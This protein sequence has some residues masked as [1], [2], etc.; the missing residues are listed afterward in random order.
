MINLE[1]H[2]MDMMF[3]QE[4]ESFLK[5]FNQHLIS[6]QQNPKETIKISGE[7]K[8]ESGAGESDTQKMNEVF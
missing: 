1:L 2:R 7:H 5:L 4:V 8:D 6:T 3:A